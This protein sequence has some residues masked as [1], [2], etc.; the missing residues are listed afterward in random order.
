M[1]EYHQKIAEKIDNNSS[2]VKPIE[3]K[4][5]MYVQKIKPFFVNGKVYYEVTFTIATDNVSKFDRV[6][7]FTSLDILENYAVKFSMHKDLI[8]I[9]N[10]KME[11]L[12]IDSWQVSIRLCELNHFGYIFTGKSE[13]RNITV[14]YKRLMSFITKS[15]MNLVDYLETDDLF[16]NTVKK[17]ICL[18]AQNIVL[19]EIL[20]YCRKI[21]KNDLP[22]SI[23][24]RYLLYKM[25]NTIIKYQIDYK[26]ICPSL[27]NLHLRN[28]CIPFETMPLTTS[29]INHNPKIYDLLECIPTKGRENEILARYIKN[30]T[31]RNGILFTQIKELCDFKNIDELMKSYNNKLY[32]SHREMRSLKKYSNTIYLNEY[33]EHC[34]FIIKELKK[35]GNYGIRNYSNSVED[36]LKKNPNLIDDGTKEQSLLQMFSTSRVALIYGSAGT[37]KSTLINYISLFF[38]NKNKLYLANTN[39]AVDNLKRKVKVTNCEYM[40]IAKFLSNRYEQTEFD[41]LFIDECSTVSNS[42][43]RKILEKASYRLLVLVGD[44]YQIEA[45]QFG[46]WFSLAKQFI[47]QTSIF[48]LKNTFRSSNEN[49]KTVWARVRNLEDGMQEA[50]DKFGY[51]KRFDNSIFQKNDKDE[52]ILC[53]NYDGLYGI[54]N[55]NSFM[56]NNNNN[57]AIIYGVHTY[58][59]GDPVLFNEKNRFAPIIYNNMKGI[60]KN[61]EED[62]EV[63]VFEIEIEASLNELDVYGYDFQLLE[64]TESKNSIIRFSVEKIINTD[65][66]DSNTNMP[67]Q[68]AYAVSIHKAQGLE[69][70]SVKIIISD[71]VEERISH[72][73]F[74]TAITR[75]RKNLLIYW[76][77]EVEHNVLTSVK[78]EIDRNRD[79]CILKTLYSL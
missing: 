31:E 56:Q 61:I 25:N 58:K 24:I 5:R 18:R 79:A 45:I 68:I 23:V 59:I 70:N 3:Y 53:L 78:K 71:E 50:I 46:N 30:N 76:S 65:F 6:I 28:G 13:I 1:N 40:T 51:S 74:Y 17:D 10:N 16:Y 75:A 48:E 44:I 52:I 41:L 35:L 8:N 54:N 20:D 67:F 72:N 37:G 4:D 22:G 64:N 32:Y 9:I 57:K 21:I 38:A 62:D 34:S 33:A 11:I 7:A 47:P 42:D 12:I 73:I 49:L 26:D 60:I 43:M 29:L 2:K 39:P 19:F 55:I 14:V 63:I 77:P 36:W 15:N 66:D 27:S 69:Y